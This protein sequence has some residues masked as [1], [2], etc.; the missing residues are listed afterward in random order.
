MDA[1]LSY[2]E[3][4]AGLRERFD[5]E[6]G[7]F[8]HRVHGVAT[9]GAAR[10]VADDV[11][12]TGGG[13]VDV[14]VHVNLELSLPELALGGGGALVLVVLVVVLARGGRTR[15]RI[16]FFPLAGGRLRLGLGL[17]A[18]F[19]RARFGGMRRNRRVGLRFGGLRAFLGVFT[20]LGG[21]GGAVGKGRGLVLGRNHGTAKG[22]TKGREEFG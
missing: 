7:G 1:F 10:D 2:D 19:A 12:D 11:A 13:E 15:G 9:D 4:T 21:G 6:F 18:G 16:A 3:V 17:R 14:W 20:R 8:G 22:A 5:E